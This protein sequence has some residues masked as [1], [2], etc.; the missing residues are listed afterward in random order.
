MKEFPTKEW[1]K[2]TINNFFERCQTK[3]HDCSRLLLM[4]QSKN[5]EPGEDVSAPVYE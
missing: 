4:R 2:T 5:G 1:K 3:Y